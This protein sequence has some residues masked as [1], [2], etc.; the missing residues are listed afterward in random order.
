METPA[1]A[2]RTDAEIKALQRR[3]MLAALARSGWKIYGPNGA[4]RILGIK[5]TTLIERMR[6]LQIKKTL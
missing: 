3:N 4:A 1:A 2:I 6:R 5:P